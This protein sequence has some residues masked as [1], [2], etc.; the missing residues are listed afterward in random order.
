MKNKRMIL[1]SVAL[2]AAVLLAPAFLFSQ[3]GPPGSGAEAGKLS[4]YLVGAI[5][6]D[7]QFRTGSSESLPVIVMLRE[8][9]ELRSHSGAKRGRLL[10]LAHGYAAKLRPSQ[11]RKL[12]DS[13]LVEYVTLD[14]P[15][16]AMSSPQPDRSGWARSSY[17]RTIGAGRSGLNGAGV[18]VAVL[19]S[20]IAPHA[21]LNGRILASVDFTSGQPS[22]EDIGR[23]PFGHG[24][25]V[26]GILAGSGRSMNGYYAGVAP[27]A[28]LVDVRVLDGQGRGTTSG[29]IAAMGWVLDNKD[30][31]GIRIANLSLG[32][33]ALESYRKDPLCRAARALVQAGIV[34]V[35]SSGN[36]GSWG[37]EYPELWQSITSPGHDPSVI[38]VGPLDTRSTATQLDDGATSFGSRG[39][40]PID[41][42]IK[43]D[44]AAPGRR[45]YSLLS[46]GSLLHETFPERVAAGSYIRMSGSSAAA[47]FVAGAAAQ[48]LQANPSL[49]PNL[50]KA[51]LMLTA[52]R[53]PS[54]HILEIGNGMVNVAGAV[55]VA[56]ALRVEDRRIAGPVR[57]YWQLDM[58]ERVW[59]GGAMA[60]GNQIVYSSLL[61]P[62]SQ[63]RTWND[64]LAWS[65]GSA[66][67]KGVFSNPDLWSEG[68]RWS[69]GAD[70]WTR[71]SWQGPVL[72]E[73]GPLWGQVIFDEVIFD[74]IIFDEVIFDEVIFD[75]IIFDEVIFDE[76]IFDEIAWRE[77]IADQVIFDEVIF[78]EIIFDEIIFDEV[79]FDE[80]IFDE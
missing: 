64:L 69:S 38:T 32:R 50:V 40:T 34:V 19:D 17:A 42:L 76:V 23:D 31:F 1:E 49:N 62:V 43:P 11:I 2:I 72:T 47:P 29:L 75:E 65:G 24:T 4:P 33:P 20:G 66:W 35:T 59:A 8:G 36:L 7:G 73:R 12:A 28:E 68:Q 3:A 30:R 46:E 6:E 52:S 57:P 78:D 74:E 27:A 41:G 5:A 54:G 18:T 63:A 70:A 10:P 26:A 80:V 45:I 9:V 61:R 51:A 37:E 14:A 67:L 77:M 16:R 15:V 25:H 53:T 13:G 48:L 22:F 21:D 71:S 56:R 39:P 55:E 60:F 44:L 79:I 58:N